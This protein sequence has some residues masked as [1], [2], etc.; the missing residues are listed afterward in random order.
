MGRT[1]GMGGG[2]GGG[3]DHGFDP[4][5]FMAEEELIGDRD[6]HGADIWDD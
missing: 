2:V 6:S 3:M 1:G 5:G 4:S